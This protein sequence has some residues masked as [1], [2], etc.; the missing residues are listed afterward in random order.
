MELIEEVWKFWDFKENS[1][2]IRIINAYEDKFEMDSF[3]TNFIDDYVPE[4]LRPPIPR[5]P[6][7]P[8]NNS[9]DNFYEYLHIWS[10]ISSANFA[11]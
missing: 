4:K 3:K 7:N 9:Y 10:A 11:V 1:K 5:L 6:S 8:I 2:V